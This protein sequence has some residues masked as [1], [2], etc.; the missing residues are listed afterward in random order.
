MVWRKRRKFG[1]VGNLKE[2]VSDQLSKFRR[3]ISMLI[4]DGTH[5]E[6]R[7]A[8]SKA[9]KSIRQRHISHLLESLEHRSSTRRLEA[10]QRLTYLIHGNFMDTDGEEEQLHWICENVRMV[11]EAD[12]MGGLMVGLGEAVKRHD[13]LA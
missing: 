6:H 13:G 8:W 7:T 10:L 3:S 9:S 4:L 5:P 11:R 12:G 2:E 1:Q